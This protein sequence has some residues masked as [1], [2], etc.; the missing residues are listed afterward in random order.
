M[1]NGLRFFFEMLAWTM[2]LFI[3]GRVG[4]RELAATN[5]AWRIN[6]IAFFPMIGVSIAVGTIVGHAQG[7]GR[8]DDSARC[9]RRGLVLAQVSRAPACRAPG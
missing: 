4:E 1:P 9:M 3:I 2:F 6:M 7:M 8:P 5:I